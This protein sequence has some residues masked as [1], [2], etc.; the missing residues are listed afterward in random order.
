M[1]QQAASGS[2]LPPHVVSKALQN[3]CVQNLARCVAYHRACLLELPLEAEGAVELVQ[4]ISD[5]GSA[6]QTI[7]AL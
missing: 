7:L 2:L 5:M 3:P 6:L 1:K 4:L